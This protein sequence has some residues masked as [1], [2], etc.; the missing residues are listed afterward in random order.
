MLVA[1]EVFVALG[2]IPAGILLIADPS[3]S[4]IGART[5]WLDDSPFPDFLIP[6]LFLVFF[7]GLFMLTAAAAHLRRL[8]VAG[9]LSVVAG[10]GLIAFVVVESFFVPF[11]VLQL[12]YVGIG[13]GIVILAY[14]EIRGDRI[15][16]STSSFVSRSVPGPR[17]QGS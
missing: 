13:A 2:A 8:N 3:G 15:H 6:G 16:G 10:L 14:F 1:M 4:G 7:N 9:L 11:S 5:E 12:L 17:E